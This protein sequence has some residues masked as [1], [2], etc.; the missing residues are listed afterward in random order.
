AV[1]DA[2][3]ET[4]ETGTDE[5]TAAQLRAD[6]LADLLLT[7]APDADPTRVDD[8]PGTLGAIRARVQVVVPA[9]TML[10]PGEEN[11]DPAALVGHGPI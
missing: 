1:I 8:G 11:V 3:N 2:R 7:A 10:R 6:I 5:R 4:S 9:L